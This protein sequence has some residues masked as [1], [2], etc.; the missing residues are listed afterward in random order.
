M[1]DIS[2]IGKAEALRR[3]YNKSK[4]Q[5]M[6]FMHYTPADMTEEVAR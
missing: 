1:I 4:P 5:G 6:G 2:K 3:L